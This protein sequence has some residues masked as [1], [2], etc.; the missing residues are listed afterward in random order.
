MYLEMP[1]DR[2]PQ[3][4]DPGYL[5]ESGIDP[6]KRRLVITAELAVRSMTELIVVYQPSS[7]NSFLVS[8]AMLLGNS[9]NTASSFC[10][11]FT[12]FRVD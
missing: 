4:L 6:V 10:S 8:C 12:P 9:S 11:S 5:G 7:Q 1:C 2:E 3:G